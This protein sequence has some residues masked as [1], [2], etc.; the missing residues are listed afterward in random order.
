MEIINRLLWLSERA[1]GPRFASRFHLRSKKVPDLHR[2]TK[3][4]EPVSPIILSEKLYPK[5]GLAV[6]KGE[7]SFQKGVCSRQLPDSLIQWAADLGTVSLGL[8]V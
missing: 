3:E 6:G 5:L 4:A 8:Q 2:A 7:S 1:N